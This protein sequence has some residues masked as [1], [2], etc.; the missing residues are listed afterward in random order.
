MTQD[1]PMTLV[2]WFQKSWQ[3]SHGSPATKAPNT[4]GVG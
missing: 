4:D 2:F 1:N 3:N